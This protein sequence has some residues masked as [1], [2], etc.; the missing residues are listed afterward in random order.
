MSRSPKAPQ[1]PGSPPV[2]PGCYIFI[3]GGL[4]LLF[5][6]IWAVYTFT[7]QARE[8]A[9]FT[10]A[11]PAALAV[12]S[13]A[14]EEVEALRARLLSFQKAADAG[15]AT[16]S[17]TVADL[18]TLLGGF[19]SLAEVKPLLVVREIKP[20]ARLVAGISFPMNS[21]PG[22]RAYLN[23]EIEAKLGYHPEAGPFISTEDIRVPGKTVP[24]GFVEIY[25]HGVI[26]GKN[27]GFL[28]EMLLKNFRTDP[29]LAAFWKRLKAVTS[30]EEAL[31]ITAGPP[32]AA[33]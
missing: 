3:I 26:P 5:A 29:A 33:P 8:L 16:L 9:A 31:V 15:E 22:R 7:K 25:Q 24:P 1:K 11:E 12:A 21:L 32:T 23:G 14:P 13:P 30:T 6:A 2:L 27:F 17:L 28:D 18:N 19:P 10:A 20:E 4:L